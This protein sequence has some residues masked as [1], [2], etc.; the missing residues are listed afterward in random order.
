MSTV[1]TQRPGAARTVGDGMKLHRRT[2]RLDGRVH[3]VISLRPGTAVR[4]STNRFHETWHL[5]SDRRG[6]RLLAHLLWGMSFQARTG[7]LLVIDHPFLT[8][9]PFD[10]D[11]ADPIVFVPGW[12]TRLGPRAAR[13]LVRQSPFRQAPEGT[14]RWRTHGL[15]A[16]GDDAFLPYWQRERGHTR[17]LGGAIVVTPT[18]PA[19]CRDWAMSAAR[20]NTVRHH[21]DHTYL[22][23][24]DHGHDGEIQIFR[25]FHRMLGTARRARSQVLHR[26]DA[27][28]DPEALRH[29]VWDRA[30][31]LNHTAYLAVRVWRDGE[32]RLGDHAARW[33][34][35]ADVHSLRDLERLGAVETYRRMRAARIPGLSLRMLWALDAAL[36]GR[37]HYSLHP[38]RKRELL[39][40]LRGLPP[41]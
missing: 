22:G 9:T 1:K 27:P 36:A 41:R 37:T 21:S 19:E 17:R 4:F 39:A 6:A 5:L 35:A 7:T 26:P 11:P 38:E 14:I 23:P 30:D 8:P 29:A 10:A 24:W 18:S 40:D 3:T 13:E 20:L 34:A 12:C 28:T 16:A 25:E 33:L 32:W 31:V 15:A 2:M